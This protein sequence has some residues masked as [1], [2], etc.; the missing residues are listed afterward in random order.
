MQNTE[1]AWLAL[2]MGVYA[3]WILFKLDL[4]MK[5]NQRCSDEH[6]NFNEFHDPICKHMDD[7][8]CLYIP[9]L[10]LF[11]FH[12]CL[13]LLQGVGLL[14]RNWGLKAA[15]IFSFGQVVVVAIPQ[16]CQLTLPT[17]LR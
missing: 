16:F 4:H 9:S 6:G 11:S 8:F 10:V 2:L 7:Q 3:V 15:T 17:R 13:I 5:K 1:G 14:E 12:V